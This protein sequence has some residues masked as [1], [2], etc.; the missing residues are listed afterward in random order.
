MKDALPSKLGGEFWFSLSM[1]LFALVGTYFAV[2]MQSTRN[3][4]GSLLVAA[5]FIWRAYHRIRMVRLARYLNEHP[6]IKRTYEAW[7]GD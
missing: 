2:R 4:M 3:L 6:D 1:I 5:A 7:S